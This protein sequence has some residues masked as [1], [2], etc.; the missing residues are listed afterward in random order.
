[1]ILELKKTECQ[2]RGLHCDRPINAWD[3]RYYMNQGGDTLPR[4]P[5]PAQ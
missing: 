4:G 2:R 1:M 3:L 5:L